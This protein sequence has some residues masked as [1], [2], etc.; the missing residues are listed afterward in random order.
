MQNNN[1]AVYCAGCGQ[2]LQPLKQV[3]GELTIKQRVYN[4]RRHKGIL[5]IWF[6]L[7]LLL[8]LPMFLAGIAGI[9]YF[10]SH[11]N[12]NISGG[13]VANIFLLFLMV[14][15][16]ASGWAIIYGFWYVA[17]VKVIFE[18]DCVI[19]RYPWYLPFFS[20]KFC[21][22]RKDISGIYLG[23][24][25]LSYIFPEILNIPRAANSIPSGLGVLIVYNNNG[26]IRKVNLPI[27]FRD[28]DYFS[29]IGKLL[30]ELDL[31]QT[32]SAFIFR[33]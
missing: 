16:A 17:K 26:R 14:L 22:E 23:R 24:V 19:Y 27:F 28:R 15:I 33:R 7:A 9:V 29:D 2:S 21:I 31:K 10:I 20:R 18:V 8:G 12:P 25:A 13:L 11:V 1:D 30:K 5:F 32:N 4:N 6:L 3:I